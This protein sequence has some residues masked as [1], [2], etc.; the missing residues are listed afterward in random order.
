MI[1][2]IVNFFRRLF[3][4]PTLA[5]AKF[6]APPLLGINAHEGLAGDMNRLLSLVVF[7]HDP[8]VRTTDYQEKASYDR[9]VAFTVNNFP[10]L[11]VMPIAGQPNY[12]SRFTDYQLGNEPDVGKISAQQYGA[13]F[14]ANAAALRVTNMAGGSSKIVT[15]GFS[16]DATVDYIADALNAGA[17]DADAICFHVYG[18]SLTL[19]LWNRMAVMREA[20]RIAAC[21]KPLWITEVGCD[22]KL[23][24]FPPT[25]ASGRE[26]AQQLAD[27]LEAVKT[28]SVER[29]YVYA[30]ATDEDKDW[31]GICR[32]DDARTPLPAWDVVSRAIR[33]QS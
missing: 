4:Q 17:K 16:N 21:T 28:S 19:A 30:L 6:V 7:A 27:F 3:G 23:P 12:V 8:L 31:F 22:S 32:H 1:T 2:A 11:V 13:A 5:P 33:T 15:A 29:C 10:T 25:L 26:Q 9:I 24:S 14:R 18:S 20:M